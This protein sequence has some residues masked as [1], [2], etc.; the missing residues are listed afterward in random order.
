[1]EFRA[2]SGRFLRR[3]RSGACRRVRASELGSDIEGSLG[4]P[5]HYCGVLSHKPSLDLI[6]ERGSGYPETP[7]IATRGEFAVIG[8]MARSAPDLAL[9][10]NVLAGPD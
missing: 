9:G 4:A 1:M 10:L 5:A 2:H 7:A 8:P 3:R 6:P